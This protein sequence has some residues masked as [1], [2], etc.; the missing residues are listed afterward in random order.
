[1]KRK[2]QLGM[3]TTWFFVFV[4]V[5]VLVM[6]YLILSGVLSFFKGPGQMRVSTIS[7]EDSILLRTFDLEGKKYLVFEGL[8]MIKSPDRG[9]PEE[10]KVYEAIMNE[11]VKYTKSRNT[12]GKGYCVLLS[13]P[14]AYF[15]VKDG[16]SLSPDV[17]LPEVGNYNKGAQLMKYRGLEEFYEIKANLPE[18]ES[19]IQYYQGE[20]V[21]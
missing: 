13:S 17:G 2:A 3:G 4:F 21:Q 15:F 10:K 12:G 19:Q 9:K 7:S 6:V 8:F 11:I 16:R 18:G 1:M 20:C 14:S 5:L